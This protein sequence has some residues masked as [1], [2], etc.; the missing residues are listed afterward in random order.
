ML[1]FLQLIYA[2]GIFLLAKIVLWIIGREEVK[3]CSHQFSLHF[4]KFIPYFATN[5]TFSEK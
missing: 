4:T 1:Q 2:H 3:W 5:E